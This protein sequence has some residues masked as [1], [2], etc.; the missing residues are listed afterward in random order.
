MKKTVLITGASSGIGKDLAH[1]FAKD[2]YDLVLAARSENILQVLATE[3]ENKYA[4]KAIVIPID[5]SKTNAA[6]DLF[7]AIQEKNIRIYALVN[8]AGFGTFGEFAE[9]SLQEETDMILVNVLALTQLTKL[10]LQEMKAQNEGQILN[11]ASVA[12]FQPGPL[13]AVYYATKA[14][15]LSFTEALA[16]E[17]KGTG[18]AVSALCPGPTQTGFVDRAKLQNSKIFSG[19]LK[20]ASSEK[21]ASIGYE[22]L[23]NGK[24]IVIPGFTNKVIT[25]SYRF[26]PRKALA[27]IVKKI[28]AKRK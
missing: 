5:L 17:L 18:I 19:E 15:V 10:F 3:M 23:Q 6:E 26:M 28:Q 13:M 7:T 14:Y 4:V 21:V 27:A 25:K 22:G 24:I 2:G 8:N 16:S 11:I 20:L 1:L 12:A 9:T